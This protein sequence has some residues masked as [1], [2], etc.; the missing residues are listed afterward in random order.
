MADAH[1]RPERERAM[2]GGHGVRVEALAIRGAR[3]GF[4]AVPGRGF[5]VGVRERGAKEEHGEE[6][7]HVIYGANP[8]D[9][10]GK[11]VAGPSR[12]AGALRYLLVVE[13][14]GDERA[15]LMSIMRYS[16][17]RLL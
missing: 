3:A 4:V 13:K 17:G 12:H 16:W 8:A 15:G 1:A 2:R 10:S 7:S 14:V 9:Q 11:H 5:G 6:R